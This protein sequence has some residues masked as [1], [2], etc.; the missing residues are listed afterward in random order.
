MIHSPGYRCHLSIHRRPPVAET[1]AYQPDGQTRCWSWRG[2]KELPLHWRCGL[3]TCGTCAVGLTLI[4]GSATAEQQG[5]QCADTTR[6]RLQPRTDSQWRLSCSYILDADPCA[7]R[8]N[9][10]RPPPAEAVFITGEED[11]SLATRGLAAHRDQAHAFANP[12]T[13]LFRIVFPARSLH[14]AV[15][16]FHRHLD[17]LRRGYFVSIAVPMMPP[18]TTPAIAPAAAAAAAHFATGNVAETGAGDGADTGVGPSSF[19]SRTLVTV[20]RCTVCITRVFTRIGLAGQTAGA[21]TLP[22]TMRLRIFSRC[23]VCC[24]LISLLPD[25]LAERLLIFVGNQIAIDVMILAATAG[26]LDRTEQR[27]RRPVCSQSRPFW[28]LYSKPAR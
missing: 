9:K 26:D 21:A 8:G 10:K 6:N 27:R 4:A 16:H 19:T 2:W 17:A 12:G 13:S 11:R 28:M 23:H 24:S 18:S 25:P 14:A 22:P 7:S 20:A 5:A 1:V 3:C 15:V